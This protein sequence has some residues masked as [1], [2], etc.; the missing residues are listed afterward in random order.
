MHAVIW[1]IVTVIDLYKLAVLVYA[2]VGLG[3]AFNII[4]RSQPFVQKLN[5]VLARLIE[6]V[7]APIRKVIPPLGNVDISP[8]I[9]FLILGFIQRLIAPY[10]SYYV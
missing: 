8:L 3:I 6:P 4:N 7:L 2:L 1:L 10:G 9:L 5:Y